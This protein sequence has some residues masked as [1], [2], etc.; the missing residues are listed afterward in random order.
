M[1]G[2]DRCNSGGRTR[3]RGTN[4]QSGGVPQVGVTNKL[5]FL[6][7]FFVNSLVMGAIDNFLKLPII[8]ESLIFEF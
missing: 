2:Y 6:I 8:S 5:F 4:V 7:F 3:S 1:P